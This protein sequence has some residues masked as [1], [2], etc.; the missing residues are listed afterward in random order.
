M[1]KMIPR[2]PY[3]D[4]L[5]ADTYVRDESVVRCPRCAR[6]YLRVANTSG[7]TRVLVTHT[8]ECPITD[9]QN[10]QIKMRLLREG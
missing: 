9:K 3:S 6:P 2:F 7:R 10:V 8:N 1:N 4:N 5:D